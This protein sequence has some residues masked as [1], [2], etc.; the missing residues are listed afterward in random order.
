M[1]SFIDP[2]FTICA[3]TTNEEFGRWLAA[4]MA[5]RGIE[6]FS[7]IEERSNGEIPGSLVGLWL[8]GEKKIGDEN[9][10]RLARA[11]RMPQV[12]VFFAA[13]LLT[14]RPD[15]PVFS[16]PVLADLWEIV[17]DM[18]EEQVDRLIAFARF[19]ANSGVGDDQKTKIGG[20]RKP[21]R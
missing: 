17:S 14:E 19:E 15:D 7:E 11:L 10:R 1:F 8:R 12:D 5:E 13:G 16:H 20:A 9:A 2:Q 18:T 4:R 6:K 3:M 21:R